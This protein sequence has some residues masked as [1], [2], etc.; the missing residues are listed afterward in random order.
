MLICL[1][2]ASNTLQALDD[3]THFC[4]HY[5]AEDQHEISTLFASKTA[6][7]F[8]SLSYEVSELGCA[9]ING[10]VAHAECAVVDRSPGGAHTIVIGQLQT[11]VI[12][13][14]SPLVCHRSPY[15]STGPLTSESSRV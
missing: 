15:A 2:N 4:V 6:D 7:K 10:A 12:T 1:D 11:A 3:A 13:G 14:G 8:S 9:V 5:L